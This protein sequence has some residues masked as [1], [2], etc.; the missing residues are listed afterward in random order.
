[1]PNTC[2]LLSF[3]RLYLRNSADME[4]NLSY[5]KYM[6]LPQYP[7]HWK[8]P[9]PHEISKKVIYNTLSPC[10]CIQTNQKLDA[11]L[12]EL[13]K[14]DSLSM[15][16]RYFGDYIQDRDQ[17]SNVT[18]EDV[19]GN[20]HRSGSLF[21]RQASECVRFT[22]SLEDLISI[23][24]EAQMLKS[25]DIE[26]FL[27]EYFNKLE[28]IMEDSDGPS[29]LLKHS[30][31]HKFFVALSS[32]N[33]SRYHTFHHPVVALIP[34][35]VTLNQDYEFAR[36]MLIQFKNLNNSLK[37]F[38]SFL[39]INDMLPVFL[40]CY[41]EDS[42]EE[43]ESVQS[44]SKALKK[45]LFVESIA[46]PL[47]TRHSN[48]DE[49]TLHP[50]ISI[51]LH[52]QI[53]SMSHPVSITL[54]NPLVSTMYDTI[55][56]IVQELM[57]PFMHRKILFWDESVLQPRR[58]IFQSSKFLRRFMSKSNQN[59]LNRT[60]TDRV[61]N[62]ESI[63]KFNS[64]SPEF[65]LRKLADWSFM[66]SDFKASYSIYEL[67]SKDWE[68]YPDYLA[69]CLESRV[70]S[71]LMGAQNIITAKTIKT[72]IEPLI[73]RSI[74]QYQLKSELNPLRLTHCILTCAD[75]L[76]SLSDTWV[77]SPLAVGYLNKILESTL[78]GSHATVLLWERVSYA[79]EVCI[80]P[81][82]NDEHILHRKYS[83]D[84]CHQDNEQLK[85][86]YKISR[87]AARTEGLTRFRKSSLFQLLAAKKW[88][89]LN[90]KNQARW[91]LE[92]VHEVYK[93]MKISS[94]TISLYSQLSSELE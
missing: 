1:M 56:R 44:L 14:V 39:N 3:V 24:S 28:Y 59:E 2:L 33:L 5:E 68:S 46:I 15:L 52:D 36:E 35:D 7:D 50:P 31:Y 51:S 83:T 18:A 88:K 32:I 84:D 10:I 65:S 80:D 20:R 11:H 19:T 81:R 42:R 73:T 89:E 22:R 82:V 69:P 8:H 79:Y 16:F 64:A 29:Q 37:N 61:D 66:L 76:L 94:R 85:K 12:M 30:M 77:S 34:L 91:C 86:Q 21:Q 41:N 62:A 27:S 53:Y 43:W 60:K 57:I 45:Q 6:N 92:Q 71:L 48:G 90:K 55:S 63:V 72:E 74:D 70:V 17:L 40:L 67:L 87:S 23:D 78:V 9:I 26:A 58:S 4:E 47:F 49:T 54:P 38:P 25:S 93:G 75:L 13:F